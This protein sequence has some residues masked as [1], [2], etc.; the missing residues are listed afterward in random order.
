MVVRKRNGDVNVERGVLLSE[1]A[2]INAIVASKQAGIARG[3]DSV[4]RQAAC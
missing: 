1:F 4:G 2:G 3:K